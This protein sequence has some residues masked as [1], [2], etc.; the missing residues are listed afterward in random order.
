M[1]IGLLHPI[2]HPNLSNICEMKLGDMNVLNI[3]LR[4]ELIGKTINET[5][6]LHSYHLSAEICISGC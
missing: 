3:G 4:I 1:L 5:N 6:F 2:K